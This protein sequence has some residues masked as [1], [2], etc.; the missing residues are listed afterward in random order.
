MITETIDGINVIKNAADENVVEI[1]E[2]SAIVAEESAN[3]EEVSEAMNKLLGLTKELDDLV[4]E[5]KL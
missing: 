1:N 2:I 3:L 4:S 5:F